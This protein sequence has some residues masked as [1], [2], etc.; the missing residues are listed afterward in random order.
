MAILPKEIF[1]F[2]AIPIKIPLTFFPELEQIILKFVLNHK[3]HQ[4]PN[5]QNSLEKKIKAG[6]IMLPGYRLYYK[7][8]VWYWHRNRHIDQWNRKESLEVNPCLYSQ[9]IYHKWGKNKQWIKD[10]P[11]DKWC[12]RNWTTACKR[13]KLEHFIYKN[14]LKWIK[15]LNVRLDTIKLLEENIQKAV[16]SLT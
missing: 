1:R 13:M 9:L 5:N 16:H 3:G 8:I 11:F 2:N 4:T 10:S 15:D 12:W 6:G 7:S 14:L